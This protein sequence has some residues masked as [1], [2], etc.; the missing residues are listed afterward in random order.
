VDNS[1]ASLHTDTHLNPRT[2]REKEKL[3]AHH[4]KKIRDVPPFTRKSLELIH[5][6]LP[7]A[8]NNVKDSTPKTRHLRQSAQRV[9]LE[10]PVPC[11]GIKKIV[12]CKDSVPEEVCKAALVQANVQVVSDMPKTIFF[13]ICVDSEADAA[14]VAALTD[15]EGVEDD[16][17]RTLSVVKGSRVERH[18]QSAEQVTPYGID[19]VKAPEF[20]ARYNGNQGAGIKVCVIDT[21]LRSS[22]EDIQDAD[23]SGS[24]NADLVTPVRNLH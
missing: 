8:D 1:R 11:L 7:D 23:I 6:I 5:P 3:E 2:L 16:P 19:L 21:G 13:A 18:L 24:D 4:D 9:T 20:W 10:H 15:V 12:Q 17:P 22:H 14:I